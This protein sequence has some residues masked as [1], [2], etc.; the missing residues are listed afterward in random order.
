MSVDRY[1]VGGRSFGVVFFYYNWFFFGF[2]SFFG[3]RSIG[4]LAKKVE[5]RRSELMGFKD[6]ACIVSS[7]QQTDRIQRVF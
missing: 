4:T 6:P 5:L 1:L 2:G 7:I 3:F